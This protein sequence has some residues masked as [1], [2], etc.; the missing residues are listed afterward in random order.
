MKDF[1][2]QYKYRIGHYLCLL[3]AILAIY[4]SINNLFSGSTSGQSPNIIL[5]ISVFLLIIILV[6][7]SIF[8]RYRDIKKN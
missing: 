4:T 3:I 6:L 1:L 5:H 2:N 7:L 8:F